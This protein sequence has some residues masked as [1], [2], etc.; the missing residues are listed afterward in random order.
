MEENKLY[1]NTN[2]GK[3]LVFGTNQQLSV[4]NPPMNMYTKKYKTHTNSSTLNMTK[5][6]KGNE[7][8]EKNFFF[9]SPRQGIMEGKSKF[10]KKIKIP[11]FPASQRTFWKCRKRAQWWRTE[12]FF[13]VIN[14][15]NN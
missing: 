12:C 3:T 7:A 6:L 1:G 11:L 15:V 14:A 13:D 5:H 10:K 2:T 4:S 9:S 8:L